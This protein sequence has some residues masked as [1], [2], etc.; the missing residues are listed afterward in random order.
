M[1]V[2]I[3]HWWISAMNTFNIL[4]KISL[5]FICLLFIL[6][7][8]LGFSSFF[9]FFCIFTSLY[10]MVP[11][12]LLLFFNMHKS[13]LSYSSILDCI[14]SKIILLIENE[15]VIS[16]Y[17]KPSIQYK[18]KMAIFTMLYYT[19]IIMKIVSVRDI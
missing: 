13:F 18:H 5:A 7:S 10:V 2:T 17:D 19:Q 6:E 3:F 14:P 1:F 8:V 9:F 12:F 16:P 4:C 11:G 15:H